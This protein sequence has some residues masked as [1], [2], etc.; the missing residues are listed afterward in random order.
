MINVEIIGWQRGFL[1]VSHTQLLQD[2]GRLSLSQAKAATDAVLSE[3]LVLI[4]VQ[5]ESV[6]NELIIKLSKIGATARIQ[7]DILSEG[8][9]FA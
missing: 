2:Q 8:S 4:P 7:N 9:E 6:A 5:N 1:K 3:K